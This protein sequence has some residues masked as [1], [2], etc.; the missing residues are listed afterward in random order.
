MKAKRL[1]SMLLAMMLCLSMLGTFTLSTSAK[2]VSEPLSDNMIFVDLSW[3]PANLP[4]HIT[5]GGKTY[6][7]TWG[8][9]AFGNAQEAVDAA[10]KFGT[11]YLCPGAFDVSFTVKKSLT[12]L[13]A[14]YG[15]D[16]NV[17]GEKESDLWTLN[18]DR[19]SGETKLEAT[20]NLGT[21]GNDV[22]A[23]A[24]EI[25]IDGITITDKGQ[26]CSNNGVAGSATL[27]FKNIYLKNSL[28]TSPVFFICPYYNAATNAYR[29]FVTFE[30]MRIEG[31]TKANVMKM[32][33]EYADISGVYMDTDCTMPLFDSASACDGPTDEV[34][35]NLHDNMFAAVV[36]RGIYLNW[37]NPTSNN[38]SL[39]AGVDN[40]SKI[41]SNVYNNIFV[42]NFATTENSTDSTISFRLKTQN[43]YYNFE[44][45][46]FYNL[47]QPL[48][49]HQSIGGYC[50]WAK[51]GDFSD[52]ITVKN[53]KFIGNIKTAYYLKNNTGTVDVSG[54]YTCVN[55]A[56]SGMLIVEN[57]KA[58][59]NWYWLDEAMSAKST[60][61]D[62]G[63]GHTISAVQGKDNGSAV[64]ASLSLPNHTVFVDPTWSETTLPVT[65]TVRGKTFGLIWGVNAFA[66]AA[67]AVESVRNF[68]TLYLCPGTYSTNFAVKKNLTILGA[69]YGIDPNVKGANENDLWTL[70]SA[71]G[72]D[73]SVIAACVNLA[74]NASGDY[75]DI[76]T[77]DG[78][79]MTGKGQF[80]CNY[81]GAGSAEINLK[82]IYIKDCTLAST[83]G[84]PL[85]LFAYWHTSTDPNTYR[86][87][88]TVDGLRVEGQTTVNVMCMVAERADISGVYM[89]TDCTKPLFIKA[90]A[91]NGPT[92]DAVWS[93]HDNM[94][95]CESGNALNLNWTSFTVNKV[96]LTAGIA[97]RNKVV[98]NVYNNVFVESTLDF[99]IESDN[100]YYN[101]IGN[102]FYNTTA[103]SGDEI[104]YGYSGKTTLDYSDQIVVTS[105]NFVG[106]MAYAYYLKN[107]TGLVDVSGNYSCINGAV[108]PIPLHAEKSQATE[109]W[110]WLDAA[111]S[112]RSDDT[113]TLKA[114]E[115]L[116]YHLDQ[117]GT[118]RAD[119]FVTVTLPEGHG[120]EDIYLFWADDNGKL[121]GYTAHSPSKVSGNT[122]SNRLKNGSIVPE[123][124][125][126]ILA[127]SYS[128]AHG[129]SAGYA[130]FDLPEG[131]ALSETMLG[132]PVAEFQAVGD[133][134]VATATGGRLHHS[135]HVR[136]MLEDIKN[137][138]PNSIGIF[139]N[140][141]TV[142]R[143]TDADYAEYLAL[144]EEIKGA[145]AIYT[146]FGNHE[147]FRFGTPVTVTDDNFTAIKKAYFDAVSSVIPE[148]AS[149]SGG[150]RQSSLSYAFTKNGYKFIS[151]G[152]DKLDQNWL[153]LND[154]TLS[155]LKTQLDKNR[156][157]T[158]PTF[159]IMHQPM[160]DTAS[161]GNSVREATTEALKT[162]L[163]D[164]PEVIMFNGHTHTS[165][166]EYNVSYQGDTVMPSIFN[167]SSVGYIPKTYSG[168]SDDT[169]GSEGYFVYVY[170][171]QVV[172]RGRDFLNNK[173]IASA[174]FIV[175]LSDNGPDQSKKVVE[176][177]MYGKSSA[178]LVIA[179]SKLGGTFS[180]YLPVDHNAD[181][182]ALFFADADAGIIGDQPFSTATVNDPYASATVPVGFADIT[183]PENADYILAYSYS[184]TLG[185][186]VNCDVVKL[187]DFPDS[188]ETLANGNVSSSGKV[189]SDKKV[190]KLGE[191]VYVTGIMEKTGDWIGMQL[192]S[193]TSGS[194]LNYQLSV[195]GSEVAVDITKQSSLSTWGKFQQVTA[196]YWQIGWI[197]VDN[198]KQTFQT[199]KLAEHL[200]TIHIIDPESEELGVPQI[201]AVANADF[202]DLKAMIAQAETFRAE[203]YTIDSWNALQTAL[204]AA[205]AALDNDPGQTKVDEL[206]QALQDAMTALTDK[207]V[208]SV[209]VTTA[210]T[211]TT[212]HQDKETLDITGGKVTVYYDN[213]TSKVIDLTIDMVSGFDNT[214][215]GSLTLTVTVEDK[216]TTFDI[217]VEGH[218]EG[219]IKVD[220]GATCGADGK[221]HTECTFC[222]ET[223]RTDIV[224]S[225]T[226]NHSYDKGVIT[227][228]PTTAKDGVKTYTC[229]VCGATKTEKLDK[230]GVN[231]LTIF[232]DIKKSDW[233]VKNGAIDFAY[234]NGLFAGTSKTT[235]GP[236]ENMTRGMFVTVLGRLHG[237]SSKGATTQFTDVKKGD[238]FSGY[239]AW[240]A[241]NGIVT[242]TS[243]TIFAPHDNVTREQICAMMVRYCDFAGIKLAKVNAPITFTD[244]KKIS[245]YARKAVA[246]CQ[247]GG[248]VGGE[249]VGNGYRFRPQGNASR[250]EVATIMMN[251]YKNY[252]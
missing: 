134:H 42:N 142:D 73:E 160:A 63:T 24:T 240:A 56:V 238:Y 241:K 72:A 183:V 179:N 216:T 121:E 233:F 132:A 153:E 26:L 108:S 31:Q 69:K 211:K 76:V 55:D 242:G 79:Q 96:D 169:V 94:F 120:A 213:N 59:E 53:N 162:L 133:M 252:K 84:E 85:Y 80:R 17:K 176:A 248:V 185:W 41:V 161:S 207:S 102:S 125:T 215:A 103:G 100:L 19:G 231:T 130:S 227:T 20:V 135:D 70:N 210:P 51:R 99:A 136:S 167:S 200:I 152:T 39:S 218:T 25:T 111:M 97:T 156:D 228:K 147:T 126:R 78:I 173:W 71:R 243:A 199:G 3:T 58:T 230:T 225:A 43:V 29:R 172:I 47:T 138:S 112:K 184:D 13:G 249:K 22:Y 37:D 201:M 202:T 229:T 164:Y 89:Y 150:S 122:V 155:W 107:N 165:L 75:A 129:L 224:I 81:S 7:L 205:K 14:K 175:D 146:T 144:L 48:S 148:D 193:V 86:R 222:S 178:D 157:M 219:E 174:Q 82:N 116:V 244:A 236:N 68:G 104:I 123:G 65:I 118:G 251:F 250:A 198:P 154:T 12:L 52:Q 171:D 119:G 217:T 208:A 223:V 88:V 62:A 196:G 83:T 36:A 189:W 209:A 40:R 4:D 16:P 192:A 143:G 60:D 101:V 1:L 10:P 166:Y 30:N 186:S 2:T 163:K 204:I 197:S 87:F 226:G 109:S 145:P 44:G 187:A 114:P 95:V 232:K 128:K 246:A 194:F 5:V 6:T 21:K 8:V 212:Y 131:A 206:T 151:L 61:T 115:S 141:D 74:A 64:P 33:A 181:N 168:S 220:V 34:V 127:Y 124:A 149:F 38:A 9:N 117:L 46:A 23:D 188:S 221:G 105:N 15:I 106:N 18:P 49:T 159:I 113:T 214:K 110:Y 190:Y 203:D 66:D 170:K 77:V 139:A 93:V 98:N 247:Q 235:F 67:V 57:S 158:R 91:S 35:W 92:T 239:V 182:V 140:G 50:D 54:N 45:N 27:N 32:T 245:S 177:P 11:V 137:I 191:P 90:G 237:V 234:N 180:C 195:A 28:H